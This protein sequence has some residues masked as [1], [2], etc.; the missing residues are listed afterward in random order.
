[1]NFILILSDVNLSIDFDL[2][3]IFSS[4]MMIILIHPSPLSTL[5]K[6]GVQI[7]NI[8]PKFSP[9]MC[10]TGRIQNTNRITNANAD[11]LLSNKEKDIFAIFLFC[12]GT[13]LILQ[14]DDFSVNV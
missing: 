6:P 11:I 9:R 2:L 1:M 10:K 12:L 5:A 8:V 3:L 14:I 13:P 7:P 4:S